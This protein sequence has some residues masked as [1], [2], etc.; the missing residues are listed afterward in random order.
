[1]TATH[2]D[3]LPLVIKMATDHCPVWMGEVNDQG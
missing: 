1:M 3:Q 2:I